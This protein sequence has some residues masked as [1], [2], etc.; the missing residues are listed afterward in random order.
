MASPSI[1]KPPMGRVG[2]SEG[3]RRVWYLQQP[4][5]FYRFLHMKPLDEG[6][7]DG[8]GVGGR[9][10]GEEVWEL[11]ERGGEGNLWEWG[12]GGWTE[13]GGGSGGVEGRIS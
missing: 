8:V 9:W 3:G 11:R 1:W 5:A 12:G 2:V 6:L 13:D 10:E 7:L 4:P